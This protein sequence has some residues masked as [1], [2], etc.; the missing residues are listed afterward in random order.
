MNRL[1]I[2]SIEVNNYRQYEGKQIVELDATGRHNINVI[3]GEN[4][5]GKS[6]LLN[7]I[8]FCLYGKEEHLDDSEEEGYPYG[9]RD[10]LKQIDKDDEITGYVEVR[11]GHDRPEY[12]FKREFTTVKKG[13]NEFSDAHEDLTLQKWDGKNW[14]VKDEPKTHLNQILPVD[15]RDYYLF[16]GE[17]LDTFFEEDYAEK[18]EKGIVDVSHIDLLDRAK[19]HLKQVRDKLQDED[20]FSGKEDQIRG[21]LQ[22]RRDR[23]AELENELAEIKEDLS[24]TREKIREKETKLEDSNNKYIRNLEKQRKREKQRLTDLRDQK[25]SLKDKSGDVLSDTASLVYSHDALEYTLEEIKELHDKGDIPPRIRE[26]FINDLLDRGKCICG[27]DIEEE[28]EHNLRDLLS[29]VSDSLDEES[30]ISAKSEIP[31]V[32][33]NEKSRVDQLL[34]L[35]GQIRDV[36]GE[37]SETESEINE[38]KAELKQQDDSEDDFDVDAIE[39]QLDEL[40]VR[41]NDLKS[42]KTQVT[43]DLAIQEDKVEDKDEELTKEL[44]KKEKHQELVQKLDFLNDT[45]NHVSNIRET[46][47]KEIRN[48]AEQKVETYFNQ[49]I[50]KDEEYEIVFEDDYTI[51]VLDEFGMN[52]RGSLSAGEKQVLAL[53]FMSALTSISGFEAPIVIDTPL[54]RIS[55]EPRNRIATNL[56]DYIE[57]TQLTFL[58]TDSEYTSKVESRLR[59]S[60]SNEY[61]LTATGRKTEVVSR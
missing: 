7:A 15:V 36:E 13:D 58:M 28:H 37:I 43:K 41:E 30:N 35:R 3:E 21:E 12:R 44:S 31:R 49:L 29:D 55:G 33:D 20:N 46:V 25:A 57:D 45:I 53:S 23:K 32:L 9:N 40:K 8:T 14:D 54:G 61:L 48:E 18:V 50:W 39:D 47:L 10:L 59:D 56:P 42:K 2:H 34:D 51:K 26:Y 11:F 52:K 60:I 5:A 38:I 1:Q 17:R 6:N 19:H 4:G 16:D 27:E 24:N 22:K